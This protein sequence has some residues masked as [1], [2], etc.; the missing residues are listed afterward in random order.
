MPLPHIE[1][2]DVTNFL[3]M[4]DDEGMYGTF[5][6]LGMGGTPT[7]VLISPEGIITDIWAGYSEGALL[8]RI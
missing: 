2:K 8:E 7:F 1:E 3:E 4:N 5:A 6:R